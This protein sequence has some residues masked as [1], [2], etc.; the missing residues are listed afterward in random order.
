[1]KNLIL[2][3]LV[4][5]LASCVKNKPTINEI[6][7]TSKQLNTQV[8]P[9]VPT[10]HPILMALHNDDVNYLYDFYNNQLNQYKDEEFFKV[11]KV[12]IIGKLINEKELLLNTNQDA[13][14]IFLNDIFDDKLPSPS[15]IEN[16]IKI[17]ENDER[18]SSQVDVK[19]I[20]NKN[21]E[22]IKTITQNLKKIR[23]SEYLPNPAT[24]TDLR[25]LGFEDFISKYIDLN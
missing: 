3:I 7:S 17:I 8:N 12:Q 6:N 13:Y 9:F 4:I 15:L 14:Q 16:L 19:G 11:G 20:L 5:S 21:K 24:E 1:M 25:F 22:F 2:L 10:Y 23:K 18:L